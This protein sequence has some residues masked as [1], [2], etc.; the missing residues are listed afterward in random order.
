MSLALAARRLLPP[1]TTLAACL[2]LLQPSSALGWGMEGHSAI[3]EIAQRHLT[4][5]ARAAIASILGE[6]VSLASISSWADDVRESRPQT[7]N[8][9]FVDIPVAVDAYDAA[10]YCKSGPKG[11][12]AV[13]ELERLRNQLRCAATDIEKNEALRF[14]VHIV[15]DIHQ[16]LHTIQDRKGGNEIPVATY[17]A[18]ATCT[19][20][21]SPTPDAANLHFVWDNVLLEKAAWDWGAIVD[22]VE[23]GLPQYMLGAS[24]STRPADWVVEAHAVAQRVWAMTPANGVIDEQYYRAALPIALQQLGRAGLRLAGLLN[25]AYGGAACPVP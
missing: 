25:E 6:G 12:C 23:R 16:P 8:W 22:R 5:E 21:C 7:Y 1:A 24:T 15:G 19:G 11:D 20:R 3:A 17:I 2:W 9:H 13:A 10:L 4:P 14:A 18:G